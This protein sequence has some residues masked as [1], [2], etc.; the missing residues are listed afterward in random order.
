MLQKKK[1]RSSN[2]KVRQKPKSKKLNL[3]A[4]PIVAANWNQKETLSQ[5]YRR[6]GLVS[7]LN[8]RSGGIEKR[9]SSRISSGLEK[10]T[11][12]DALAIANKNPTS[13]IPGTVRIER[14]P[15]TGAILRVL[16]DGADEGKK[17]GRRE[18][19]GRV[20]RDELDESSGGEDEERVGQHDLPAIDIGMLGGGEGVVPELVLQAANTG[21]RKRPRKQS[22]REE[23]WVGR[24]VEKYGDDVRRM[25]KDKRLNPMQQSEADIGM[26]VRTWREGRRKG[27]MDVEDE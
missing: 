7:K 20:L 13:L 26:R 6:L 1:N 5:N 11:E 22:Q 8:A 17:R 15:E 21:T 9:P 24:L 4:N 12:N 18:W 10:G 19:N 2:P 16:K 25:A 14:D 27:N 23:E 3:R